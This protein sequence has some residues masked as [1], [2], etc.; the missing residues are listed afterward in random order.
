[1]KDN[2]WM[3]VATAI[4]KDSK[5]VSMVVGCVLV[6][7][8]HIISTGVNGTPKEYTNCC[9]K[10]S[11]RCPEHSEWSAKYEIHAEMNSIIHC[12]VST[13]GSTAFVTHSPCFNCCKHLAAA[14]VK[15]IYYKERYYRMSDDEFFEVVD[16]C[17]DMKIK[18]KELNN[19]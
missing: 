19:G 14:G 16:F 8:G 15:A 2:T 4:S 11:S 13:Y 17:K 5:C 1:M 12:P 18:F 3:D 9:D 6:K 7:D 10:F